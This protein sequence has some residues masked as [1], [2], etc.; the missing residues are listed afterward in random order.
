MHHQGHSGCMSDLE[1]MGRV[2][3]TRKGQR[4]I[5]LAVA[6]I[7]VFAVSVFTY[8]SAIAYY[9]PALT[10]AFQSYERPFA[11]VTYFSLVGFESIYSSTSFVLGTIKLAHS[12]KNNTPLDVQ[13][14]YDMI[15][16]VTDP[17][18]L[19]LLTDAKALR[20]CGW[21]IWS[22]QPLYGRPSAEHYL[23]Q[24]RYTHSAQFSKLYLWSLISYRHV[25]YLDSD[26]LLVGDITGEIS[27][28]LPHLSRDRVG[29]VVDRGR[30]PT[31]NAGVILLVPSLLKFNAM[32]AVTHSMSYDVE[33]QEQGFLNAFWNHSV[34]TL[35][36]YLNE[37]VDNLTDSCLVMH[38]VA[39]MK[40]WK[41]CNG[42]EAIQQFSRPCAEWNAVPP[43][44]HG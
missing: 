41:I 11:L 40:P 39:G 43:F 35:P 42:I 10:S 12:W 30:V 36:E 22:V 17:Y 33:V 9:T 7:T 44:T 24:N 32:L 8:I 21:K 2:Y 14:K 37:G 18:G 4:L 34:V 13:L 25:L 31:Y 20:D 15:L 6:T 16:L 5:L 26:V 1:S 28:A 27:R 19:L 23:N 29:M 38:F 3:F